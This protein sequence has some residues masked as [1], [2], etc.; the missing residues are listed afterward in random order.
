[1][2]VLLPCLIMVH[3][4]VLSNFIAFPLGTL[5]VGLVDS[6]GPF[7]H[8]RNTLM[9]SI[10]LYFVLACV[11]G[12]LRSYPGVVF[13]EIVV[14]GIFFSL[15]SVYGTRIGSIGTIALL[16]FVFN[17]DSHI[18]GTRIF[19]SAFHFAAGGIWYFILFIF[20]HHIRPYVL[21][22]QLLGEC[23][24]DT[25]KFLNIKSK[26]YFRNPD[27]DSLS[28]EL[29]NYQI[30]LN[31]QHEDLREII[32]KTRQIASESTVRSRVFMLMY[33]DCEELLERVMNSQQDYRKLQKAFGNSRILI[34]FGTYIAM[35]A[36]EME[37]IGMAVQSGRASRGEKDLDA[38]LKKCADAF[39]NFR[40]AHINEHNVEDIIMLRQILYSLQDITERVNKLHHATTF[41]K[42]L[43]RDK[44]IALD[45]EPGIAHHELNPRLLIDNI[46]LKSNYFRMAI[47]LTV[48]LLIGYI[49]SLFFSVGH[50]Y[51]ILLT[52]VTIIKPSYS[53]TK[54][55]NIKR[56][57]GTLLGIAVGFTIIY[58]TKNNTA[59]FLIMMLVMI[60]SYAVLKLNYFLA[61]FGITIYVLISSYFLAP[62]AFDM[63]LKD[64]ILDTA[65]GSLIAWIVSGTVLPYWEH[66][67]IKNYIAEALKE[68]WNYFK[69][70]STPFAGKKLDMVLL[71]KARKEAFIALANLSDVFQRMLSDPKSQ[72][73]H[74]K[75]YHQF[76]ATSQQLTSYIASLSNYAQD[77]NTKYQSESF[78]KIIRH[79]DNQFLRAEKALTDQATPEL[80]KSNYALPE[81]IE[82]QNLLNIRK[83][84]LRQTKIIDIQ[85]STIRKTLT[86]MKTINGLFELVNTTTVDE[87]KILQKIRD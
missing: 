67:Q 82:L 22:G 80:D 36:R 10:V 73:P 3:Y 42:T 43:T 47:R 55:R 2:G 66:F 40:A 64:R 85:N 16:V 29:M 1:L 83:K 53:I 13:I 48:A 14:Y 8:R 70:A 74:M 51:W 63:V 86:D 41:D 27:Y 52:I 84:Q 76:T 17:I 19:Q 77:T 7:I 79:I 37:A 46:S 24:T 62:T 68:N 60:I 61:S 32:F 39:Y 5:F 25:G 11:T 49:V 50:N 58:F 18:S 57:G 69:I 71:S 54:A 9:A 23:F 87:I 21:I 33:L 35:L 44:K 15:I 81:N 56:L 65:I 75:E 78:R 26:F 72:R 31:K 20:L 6:P 34:L 59:L 28:E 45:K 4:G 30:T 38:S 12:W